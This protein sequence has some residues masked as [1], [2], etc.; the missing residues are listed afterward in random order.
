MVVLQP[1][2]ETLTDAKI[3]S[4]SRAVVDEVEKQ[5]GGTLRK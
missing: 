5:T 4:V 2:K 3:E 1:E